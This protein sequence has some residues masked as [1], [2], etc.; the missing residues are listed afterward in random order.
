MY[1]KNIICSA[2]FL[3]DSFYSFAQK[4]DLEKNYSES[5]CNCLTDVS[6]TGTVKEEDLNNCFLTSLTEYGQEMTLDAMK[7]YGDSS[8]KY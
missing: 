3:F 6:K 5:F 1:L 8:E 7:E 4:N 2:T